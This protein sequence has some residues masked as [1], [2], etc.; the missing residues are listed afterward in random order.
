MAAVAGSFPEAISPYHGVGDA[1][2]ANLP[3]ASRRAVWH[4]LRALKSETSFPCCEQLEEA[5][6][7]AA[8]I[9]LEPASRNT[10]PAACIA[11][12]IAARSDPDSIVLLAPSDHLIAD[13]DQFT[14][15][16]TAGLASARKGALVTFGVEPDCPH[17]GYGYIETERANGSDFPVRRFVEKPS[18]EAAQ[19]YFDSG[20]FYWNVGIFL[21]KAASMIELMESYAPDILRA[22]RPALDN[23]VQDFGFLRLH[24]AYAEAPAVSLQHAIAEKADNI[25][26]AP[27]DT[28]WNDVD[29][30]LA[31]WRL[32]PKDDAGNVVHGEGEVLLAGTRGSYAYSDHGCLAV[33]GLDNVVVVATEDAVLVG[34]KAHVDSVKDIVA[35]LKAND[36]THA[37]HHNRIYRPWGWYETLN[38]GDG[39]QVKRIMVKPGGKLSLQSHHHRSEH[40]V[41]VK[42]TL[43]VTKGDKVELLSEN[44]STYIPVGKRH[45]LAN[46]GKL[47]AFLIEVQSGLY[48]E[49]DDIVRFDDIYG[50]SSTD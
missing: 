14:K 41:I 34:S 12:L 22:C 43:E 50:R 19:E 3:Q 17:T 24:A 44:E 13:A 10:A 38:R 37:L 49:E 35:R 27:L 31:V 45:R 30:W 11:A 47:P 29:S 9:V 39:Y 16:I 23:A 8:N 5:G 48:L 42:G 15:A 33:I 32:M 2:P 25:R 36:R 6:T 26:C 46:P 7:C 40:W 18:L 1:V 20:R 28:A 4:S 21:F